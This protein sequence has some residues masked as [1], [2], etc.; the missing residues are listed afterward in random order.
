MSYQAIMNQLAKCLCLLL[1]LCI[2]G[3]HSDSRSS[4]ATSDQINISED[5]YWFTGVSGHQWANNA[6]LA[7]VE[8][9]IR[10]YQRGAVTVRISDGVGTEVFNKRYGFGG[11]DWVIG[12]NEFIDI[13]FT[14]PAEPGVWAIRLEF[15]D[16][17]GHLYLTLTDVSV[18]EETVVQAPTSTLSILDASFGDEGRAVWTPDL[19]FG[20]DLALDSMGRIVVAG[21]VLDDAGQRELAVGRFT[22]S[23]ALDTSFA[24][25]GVFRWTVPTAS[26]ASALALDG[27]DILVSG[28]R[29]DSSADDDLTV[30]RL[31][32]AGA[33]DPGF[34]SGGVFSF[35]DDLEESGLDIALDSVGRVLVTG[36]SRD[37]DNTLGH[38]LLLR[39]T[40]GGALDPGFG[41]GGVVQS[42]E[43]SDRG[44]GVVVDGSDRPI[45]MGERNNGLQLWKYT[46][47]GVADL[48]FGVNGE[49]TNSGAV[50]EVRIGR[51]LAQ[52]S[53]GE[54]AVTGLLFFEAQNDP[55]DLA[56]WRFSADGNEDVGFGSDG[57]VTYVFP[58][59]PAVGTSVAFDSTGQIVVLGSTRTR[60]VTQSDASATLWRFLNTG[61]LDTTLTD[62]M[63]TGVVRFD[64]RLANTATS[65]NACVFDGGEL[66]V[67][68]AVTD[69]IDTAIDVLIWKLLP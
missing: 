15:L 26:G 60:D 53:S 16:F 55:A 8:V 18:T 4:I 23:G 5:R 46:T 25:D 61:D 42:S 36:S 22:A 7:R 47:T 30:L 11:F 62:S 13:S 20:A 54:L 44:R 40:A 31:T 51:S 17:Y 24:T 14:D 69:H 66:F 68:G 9:R 41:V 58:N 32:A 57:L 38:M 48:T 2:L 35:D 49:V 34:A 65:G 63:S 52:K 33:L 56:V 27:A 28:Y 29:F 64:A 45:V 59:G 50:D 67:S 21:T 1:L 19:G 12:S 37:L 6:T 3:C 10:G 39:L 43:P